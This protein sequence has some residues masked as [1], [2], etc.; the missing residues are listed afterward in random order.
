MNNTTDVI[1]DDNKMH[2]KSD[3]ESESEDDH[4]NNVNN[5]NRIDN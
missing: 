2:T 3:V 5:N 4:G 1:V